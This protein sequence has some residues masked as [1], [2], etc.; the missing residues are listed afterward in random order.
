MGQ[1]RYSQALAEHCRLLRAAFGRH[2]GY[3]VDYEGD[4]FIVAFQSASEALA[5]AGDAQE[6]LAAHA[7]PVGHELRVRMGIHTGEPMLAPPKYVGLDVHKAARIMASG[8]GGQVLVSAAT[9][10]FTGTDGLRDLGEHRLKDIEEPLSIFNSARKPPPLKTISNTNLP[11]PASSFL[12]REAEL[13]HILSRI[14]GGARLVTLTGPGG[15][16]NTRLAIEVAS[17]LV[18]LL[19]RRGLLD[20]SRSAPA[21]RR[22]SPRQSR[23]RSAPSMGSKSTSASARSC[24]SSTTWEQLAEAAPEL[25]LPRRDL[26]HP[27][28]CSPRAAQL[29]RVKGEVEYP[30]PPLTEPEAVSLFC[31]RAQA[32]AER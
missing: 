26:P 30:V 4:A 21:T 6:A 7:W 16:G 15:T 14:E 19:Q 29:L 27:H 13:E 31:E 22:L 18:P 32:R 2:L 23:K 1:D 9:T 10:A 17:S 5:A 24:S 3:E 8:Y 25:L 20:R 28:P 12:G 11:R